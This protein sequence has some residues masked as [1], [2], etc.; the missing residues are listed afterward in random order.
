MLIL[1]VHRT[2]SVDLGQFELR[3]GIEDYLINMHGAYGL[4]IIHAVLD[5]RHVHHQAECPQLSRGDVEQLWRNE[6]VLRSAGLSAVQFC[7]LCITNLV[8]DR[9]A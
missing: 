2:H 5:N 6:S 7:S 1:P 9:V 8:G 3:P 4:P